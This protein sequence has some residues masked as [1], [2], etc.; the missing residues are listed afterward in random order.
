MLLEFRVKNFLSFRDEQVFSLVASSDQTH[1]DTH[2]IPTGI[3]SLPHALKSVAI[4]GP[5]AGGKSNLIQAMKRMCLSVLRSGSVGWMESIIQNRRFRLDPEMAE[6]PIEFDVTFIVD[7]VRYQYGF[8][9][10]K[11]R[12]VEEWL[13]AYPKQRPQQWFMRCYSEEKDLDEYNF[14]ANLKGQRAQWQ[15]ATRPDAL[16][17]TMAVQLNSE[18]LKPIYNW[19]HQKFHGFGM[20]NDTPIHITNEIVDKKYIDIAAFMKSADLSIYDVKTKTDTTQHIVID[21]KSGELQ[22][23]EEESEERS[24]VFKHKGALGDAWFE[25]YEE[26]LGTQHLYAL[27]GSLYKV[28]DRGDLLVVDELDASLHTHI[29]LE[30]LALFHNPETNPN[31]AQLI[32]TTH[33]TALLNADVL[34]RDQVCFVGKDENQA[35]I[36]SALSDFSPRKGEALEKNYLAGRYGAVPITSG[37][38]TPRKRRAADG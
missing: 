37:L 28:L 29:V 20:L 5:N 1:A 26:S 10:T 31:G 24:P 4:Y 9:L 19:F 6:A 22:I 33:N 27:V 30:I 23:R 3:K 16:F 34:R 18:K 11:M 36:I 7:E 13:Y 21:S 32:F 38:A 2:L 8:C 25:H 12:V 14:S 35:S 15:A 17:L